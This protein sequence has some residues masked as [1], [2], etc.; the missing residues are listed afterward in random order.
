[1]A[2]STYVQFR[3]TILDKLLRTYTLSFEVLRAKINDEISVRYPGKQISVRTLRGDIKYFRTVFKAPIPQGHKQYTYSDSNFSIANVSLTD[4]DLKLI[5]EAQNLL[6]RFDNHP[7]YYRLREALV[8]LIDMD[9]EDKSLAS[10]VI[11]YDHNDEYMGIQHLKPMFLAIK[12]KQVLNIKYQ[13]YAGNSYSFDFH[14]QI[15][16][17]YNRRYF[18][19]GINHDKQGVE[20]WSIPLDNRLIGFEPNPQISY[21]EMNTDWSA[22][23]R[24]MVGVTKDPNKGLEQVHL[25]FKNGRDAYFKSKPFVSDYDY[26]DENSGEVFFEIHINLELIQQILS[27]GKDVVVLK[28][29]SLRI[30]LQKE[31]EQMF[32]NYHSA[33]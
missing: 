23:F 14:P 10:K 2:N 19:F 15:I 20:K 4:K 24:N 6:E 28:P 25:K 33:D 11:Y 3:Y 18:V 9:E 12:N 17:Q 8:S 32:K 26:F 7:K 22:Y 27:Y 5:E 29:E 31:V 1:M 30:A 21:Q 13:P 16:K